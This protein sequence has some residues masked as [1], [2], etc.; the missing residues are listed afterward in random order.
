MPLWRME[1]KN[2]ETKIFWFN[3]EKP[4]TSLQTLPERDFEIIKTQVANKQAVN[5][6][7]DFLTKQK[8][9]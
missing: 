8:G 4:I 3:S 6:W 2:K 9:N 5:L 1:M 7:L